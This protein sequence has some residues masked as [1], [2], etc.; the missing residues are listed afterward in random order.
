MSKGEKVTSKQRIKIIGLTLKEIMLSFCEAATLPFFASNPYYRRSVREYLDSRELDKIAFSKKIYD[1]K[2]QGLAE[3]EDID[4]EKFFWLT[5]KGVKRVMRYSVE[6]LQI[7]KPEKW[8]G[9]FR[10]VIFDI[11]EKLR[12]PRA[13]L[14]IKLYNLQFVQIQKS[15]YVHPYPCDEEIA[16]ITKQLL[17]SDFVTIMTS[18]IKHGR[19]KLT[20]E[21]KKRGLLTENDR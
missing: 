2:R 20:R 8:D 15:A 12:Y 11:P 10:V 14:R 3:T 5:A 17:L 18:E 1:L 9:K 21:F 13:L 4:G 7:P 19:E 6:E 16:L